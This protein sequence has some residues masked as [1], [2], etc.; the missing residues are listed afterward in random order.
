MKG[1]E[2]QSPERACSIQRS[3]GSCWEST[4]IISAG[5]LISFVVLVYISQLFF[6]FSFLACSLNLR[7]LVCSTRRQEDCLLC[8][9]LFIPLI[10]SCDSRSCFLISHLYFLTFSKL[11]FCLHSVL[12][13]NQ[14]PHNYKMCEF[15]DIGKIHLSS[16]CGM[17]LWC[18]V[19]SWTLS[20]V[21]SSLPFFTRR[22][23]PYVCASPCWLPQ[24]QSVPFL[25]QNAGEGCFNVFLKQTNKKTSFL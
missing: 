20:E 18:P 13:F 10:E 1:F 5:S 2:T 22:L 12:S 15:V 3:C 19:S 7:M 8:A 6:T 17:Y 9:K 25:T 21:W 14:Q 11:V 23:L 24:L 16:L 4:E